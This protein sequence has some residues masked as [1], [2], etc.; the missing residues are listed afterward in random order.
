MP[1][2]HSVSHVIRFF[3]LSFFFWTRGGGIDTGRQRVRLRSGERADMTAG[4]I[5]LWPKRVACV[6]LLKLCFHLVIQVE[7]CWDGKWLQ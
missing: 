6:G 3:F 1:P 4:V 2:E 5:R 7:K